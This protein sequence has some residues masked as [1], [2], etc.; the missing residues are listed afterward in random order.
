M[1]ALFPALFLGAF[2]LC[3]ARAEDVPSVVAAEVQKS[4]P[5]LASKSLLGVQLTESSGAQVWELQYQDSNFKGD[6]RAVV[7]RNGKVSDDKARTLKAFPAN[8]QPLTQA[9]L[10]ST[11]APHRT[12]ANALAA[13]AKVTPHSIRYVL[14]HREGSPTTWRILVF[15]AKEQ[16]LGRMEINAESGQLISSS[17]GKE[18]TASA[19]A[20]SDFEQFGDDVESTFKGIGGDLEEFFTGKRTI[21]K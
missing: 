5:D 7:F 12:K 10:Q 16:R 8:S 20:R 13:D 4:L 17:W 3:S 21:D 1:K 15:D 19:Q 18:I 2:L 11:V 6:R 9:D 14:S